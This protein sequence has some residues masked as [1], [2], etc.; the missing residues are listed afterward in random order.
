MSLKNSVDKVEGGWM[1]SWDMGYEKFPLATFWIIST[2]SSGQ[3]PA[4]TRAREYAEMIE[5][6]NYIEYADNQIKD[7]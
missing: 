3:T 7:R 2:T 1:V 6:R 4:E 5:E